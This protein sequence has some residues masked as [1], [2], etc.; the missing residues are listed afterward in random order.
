M[1][2]RFFA[3][4]KRL[5]V[6]LAIVHAGII[7]TL[8][9]IPGNQLPGT[10]FFVRMFYNLMHAPMFALLA[11]WIA[12]AQLERTPDGRG[13]QRL[14]LR[15]RSRV[16]SVVLVLCFAVLDEYHQS[17]VKMRSSDPVDLVTDFAGA[18]A[19]V[20]LIHALLSQKQDRA[21]ALKGVAAC[22]ALALSSS[23][24]ASR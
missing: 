8:S 17:F 20:C 9:S 6:V 1:I 18:T 7:T 24:F 11:A 4:P 10:G 13:G 19:A 2:T 15:L 14:E 5:F 3:L 22:I 23:G 21:R 12:L 16:I